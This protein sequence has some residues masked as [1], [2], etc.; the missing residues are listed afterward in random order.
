LFDEPDASRL[1][2]PF[3]RGPGDRCPDDRRPDAGIPATNTNTSA[4]A[5]A[6]GDL[7]AASDGDIDWD[8]YYAEVFRRTKPTPPPI[9][10][11]RRR[12]ANGSIL[13]AI[14]L[15]FRDVFDPEKPDEAVVAE[16]PAD[17]DRP[18]KPFHLEFDPDDPKATRA[19]VRLWAKPLDPDL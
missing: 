19:I 13:A 4:A 8:A 11:I 3:P 14:V 16:A 9:P 15:G 18:D 2:Q 6:E 10:T 1:E 17:P 5:A 7:D 12:V